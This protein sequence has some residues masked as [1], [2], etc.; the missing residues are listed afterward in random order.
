MILRFDS[1]SFKLKMDN[2]T[3]KP[4]LIQFFP[5]IGIR[6]RSFQRGGIAVPVTDFFHSYERNLTLQFP[7]SPIS[8]LG[9]GFSFLPFLDSLPKTLSLRG[10]EMFGRF[11]NPNEPVEIFL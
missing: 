3:V 11:G 8:G 9:I 1:I 2:F 4:D 7:E 10:A 5:R 6:S